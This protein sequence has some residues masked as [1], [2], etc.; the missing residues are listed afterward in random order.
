[1]SG[2]RISQGFPAAA[3]GYGSREKERDKRRGEASRTALMPDSRAS[4]EKDPR[5][6]RLGKV[7][8]MGKDDGRKDGRKRSGK[9]EKTIIVD[10]FGDLGKGK[11]S[12]KRFGVVAT[13]TRDP[14]G[15]G[16]IAEKFKKKAK[17]K[18][19]LKY[20]SSDPSTRNEMI[21]EISKTD[22]D[23]HAVFSNKGKT[24]GK[25]LYKTTLEAAIHDV[26]STN[27]AE[28][29]DVIYDSHSAICT[30][31]ARSM[32]E[33]IATRNRKTVR[34]VRVCRSA[35]SLELQTHDFVTGAVGTSMMSD[36]HQLVDTLKEKLK[37][38]IIRGKN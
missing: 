38:R 11:R 8:R 10:E 25:K 26:M 7:K 34:N 6:S 27:T 32:T 33:D 24:T 23:I 37:V 4:G 12:S 28:T 30:E 36:D 35:E 9:P 3:V 19:E 20:R 1:M 17:V 15:F 31:S 29:Y 2:K 16:R 13:V 18:G 22:I 21:H 5:V 14:K